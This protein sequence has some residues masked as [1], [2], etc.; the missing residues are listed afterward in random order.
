[1]LKVLIFAD[2]CFRQVWKTLILMDY[3][4]RRALKVRIFTDYVFDGC[5]KVQSCWMTVFDTLRIQ[6]ADKPKLILTMKNKEIF[7]KLQK[8]KE[9]IIR[10]SNIGV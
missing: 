4:F 7:S 10:Q 5:R 8:H 1:M 3:S 6:K 9:W 2:Y